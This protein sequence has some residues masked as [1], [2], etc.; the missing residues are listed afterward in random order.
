MK[1]LIL[2]R[3]IGFVRLSLMA[4]L[5]LNKL[6]RFFVIFCLTVCFNQNYHQNHFLSDSPV[7]STRE[8][9]NSFM[10]VVSPILSD[11]EDNDHVPPRDLDYSTES[12]PS[13]QEDDVLR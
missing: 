5:F 10:D 2:Y 8:H 9:D 4:I 1:A 13:D 11:E 7:S 6:F 12:T 3:I